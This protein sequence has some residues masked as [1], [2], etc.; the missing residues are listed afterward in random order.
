MF[1]DFLFHYLV[2]INMFRLFLVMDLISKVGVNILV[3]VFLWTYFDL[4][5]MSIYMSGIAG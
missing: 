3:S 5:S 2:D 4:F 1:H